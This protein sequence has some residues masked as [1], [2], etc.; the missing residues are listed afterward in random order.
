M[1]WLYTGTFGSFIGYSAAFP[2]LTKTQFPDI[3]ALKYA[4]VGPLVG[5]LSRSLTGWVSDRWG[6]GRVTLWVFVAMALGAG[7]LALLASHVA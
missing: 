3:V 7:R 5:A 4:F 2:L 1:C 6:G